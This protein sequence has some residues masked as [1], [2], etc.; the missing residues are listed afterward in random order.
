MNISELINHAIEYIL[1]H[2]GENVTAAKVAEHCHVSRFY[3]TKIFK[4]QTGESVYAFIKKKKLEFSA[5][6]LKSESTRSITDI[7][8][9]YGYSPSNYS[10]A[11]KDYFD[12]SPV[13]FRRERFGHHNELLNPEN[14]SVRMIYDEINS[15]VSIR[16]MPQY[17]IVYERRIG[18]YSEMKNCWSDFCKR[19]DRFHTD[20]TLYFE[21]TFDDPSITDKNKCLYD[22]C[23]SDEGINAAAEKCGGITKLKLPDSAAFGTISGGKFAVCPFKGYLS[24]INQFHR[25][26]MGIWLPLCGYSLDSRYS[27]DL[28]HKVEENTYYM[29][30]D[31]CIPIK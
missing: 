30:F 11:F 18:N 2:I 4:Q 29:E 5:F 20:Q 24:E 31:V 15:T 12:R 1:L 6:M 27:Y 19:Y 8:G 28:Y 7:A 22:I 17:S 25:K 26:L 13:E 14:K 3:F 23:M 10:S 9:E 21:R 16:Q